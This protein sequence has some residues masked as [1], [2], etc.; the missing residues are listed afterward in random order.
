[1]YRKCI[2]LY[3][4]NT[5]KLDQR[6]VTTEGKVYKSKSYASKGYYIAFYVYKRKRHR[7]HIA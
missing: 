2:L 6:G 7:L 5:E 4:R 3:L 1:M